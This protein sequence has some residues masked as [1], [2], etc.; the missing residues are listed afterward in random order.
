[1]R[2]VVLA[3]V[4]L[5][6]ALASCGDD[7]GAQ[8]SP[9][10]GSPQEFA[11]ATVRKDITYCSPGAKPQKLD[12]IAPK[13]D[14]GEPRPLA[15]FFH[16]GG[17]TTGARQNADRWFTGVADALIAEGFVVA[18]VDYRLAGD[19]AWSAQVE[20]GRCAVRFLRS[21]ANDYGIDP[22]RVAAWGESSGA[23]LALMLALPDASAGFDGG[24]WPGVP[25]GVRAVVDLWGPTDLTAT[26][27][28]QQQA[29]IVKRVFGKEDAELQRASP[30]TYASASA[31]PML[32]V[33]GDADEVVPLSQSEALE[34][35]LQAAGAQA[36]LIT[37]TGGSHDL[38]EGEFTPSAPE[39]TNRIVAF[40]A[41][42]LA[43]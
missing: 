12:L 27:V 40:I 23:W 15:V 9:S 1:M 37:V 33:H 36:Q 16:G 25:S 17:W 5:A 34:T 29:R 22:E 26:D 4:L 18:T 8:A 41:S 21:H 43:D 39:L 13:D 6:L 35:K 3:F 7:D 32:I 2:L 42:A 24:E 11:D 20:D 14:A 19:N 10:P 38:A 28:P 30:L 31:P